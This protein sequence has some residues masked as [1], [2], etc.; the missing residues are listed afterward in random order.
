MFSN[1]LDH[2]EIDLRTDSNQSFLFEDI[3][4][5]YKHLMVQVF[6]KAIKDELQASTW[7]KILS[8]RAQQ[9]ALVQYLNDHSQE[10]HDHF[11]QLITY[12]SNHAILEYLELDFTLSM[13]E[14]RDIT[15]FTQGLEIQAAEDYKKIA[16]QAKAVGDTETKLF[17]EEMMKD[18]LRH[19][20]EIA[21]LTSTKRD[22]NV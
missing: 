12:A 20:D 5:D 9:P 8:E 22:F 14:V 4:E 7:Y 6:N 1:F 2:L 18:E 21:V 15:A 17:F 13:P 3:T 11:K 19:Y 16:S 10:E